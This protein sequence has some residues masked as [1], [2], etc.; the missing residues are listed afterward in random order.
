MLYTQR[1]RARTQARLRERDRD[2]DLD[3]D[4]EAGDGI[5]TRDSM[6]TSVN[7]GGGNRR[8]N[9]QTQSDV[10]EVGAAQGGADYPGSSYGDGDGEAH[11]HTPAHARN[12]N[13]DSTS[14]SISQVQSQSQS[15]AASVSVAHKGK[16]K[17]STSLS[18]AAAGVVYGS[19]SDFRVDSFGDDDQSNLAIV[20]TPV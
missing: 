16:D 15:H 13:R 14:Q 12:I 19:V 5:D 9:T 11:A 4:N 1:I 10:D 18:K 7:S 3:N 17:P 2:R 8:G 6:L 20:R